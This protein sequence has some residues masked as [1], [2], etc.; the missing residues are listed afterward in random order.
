MTRR[1]RTIADRLAALEN[2]DRADRWTFTLIN[3]RTASLPVGAVLDAVAEAFDRL[4]D[5]DQDEGATAAE[6][7]EPSRELRLLARVADDSE[8]SMLGSLA[9]RLARA[10]VAQHDAQGA[11]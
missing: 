1:R 7:P 8:T 2:A 11:A 9:V 4:D 10:T 3:G 6:R 5:E